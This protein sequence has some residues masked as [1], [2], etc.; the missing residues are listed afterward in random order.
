MEKLRERKGRDVVFD[1]QK[2]EVW[3]IGVMMLTLATLSSEELIYNWK[4]KI[5]DSRGLEHLFTEIKM[6][7]SPLYYDLIKMCLEKD[8]AKR[9]KLPKI[10]DILKTRREAYEDEEE[11]VFNTTQD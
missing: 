1:K 8:P 9:C 7:Y 6:R 4:E 3:A 5:I 2:A 10:L 11:V